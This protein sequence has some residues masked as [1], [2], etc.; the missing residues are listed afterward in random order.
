MYREIGLHSKLNR[1][2]QS[3]KGFPHSITSDCLSRLEDPEETS[4]SEEVIRDVSGVMF[5]GESLSSPRASAR[6]P[7]VGRRRSRHGTPMA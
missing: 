1:N 4:F 2:H 6:V 7:H 3:G 5:T